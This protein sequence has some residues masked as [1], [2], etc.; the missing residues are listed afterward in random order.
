MRDTND[1]GGR[2]GSAY[3]PMSEDEQEVL[4][5]LVAAGDLKVV[6]KGWTEVPNPRI[7]VGDLRVSMAFR[8]NFKKPEVPTPVYFF[9]LELRTNSGML[10]FKEKQP[11]MYEGKPITVADGMYL[12]M[13]WDIAIMA[14]PP[15]LVKA[16]KPGA[17]G[18]TSKWIDKD[19][20]D[21]TLLGNT[22]LGVQKQ[23]KLRNIREGEAS[24]RAA[25]MK[26]LMEAA[27]MK[28]DGKKK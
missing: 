26:R 5:R 1:F 20:G 2:K 7:R 3:T 14:M 23:R 16:L 8:I 15:N 25:T 24:S 19:T 28:E 9:D 4:D 12:D 17:I 22:R 13:V 18:L 27:A 11:A 10:L 6:V 21:I